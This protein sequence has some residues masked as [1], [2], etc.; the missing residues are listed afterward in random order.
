MS[1]TGIMWSV[2]KGNASLL[3][4]YAPSAFYAGGVADAITVGVFRFTAAQTNLTAGQTVRRSERAAVLIR[5]F[6]R[7]SSQ[8]TL[9]SPPS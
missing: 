9:L 1:A 6:Y 3:S 8:V 7:L 5:T 4:A 2:G